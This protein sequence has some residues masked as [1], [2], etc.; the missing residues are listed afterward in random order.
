MLI[1]DFFSRVKQ[2]QYQVDQ[3]H[4]FIS[5]E[6]VF[7]ELIKK[8]LRKNGNYRTVFGQDVSLEWLENNILGLSLFGNEDYIIVEAH[9]IAKNVLERLNESLANIDTRLILISDKKIEQLEKFNTIEI[10]APNFWQMDKLLDFFFKVCRVKLSPNAM[11]F[12]LETQEAT[13]HNYYQIAMILQSNFPGKVVDQSDVE[14]V[15]EK[16]K[17]DKFEYASLLSRKDTQ[18]FF[19]KLIEIKSDTKTLRNFFLF[20]QTHMLKI[21]DPSYTNKKN[22]LS[23]YDNEIL[24]ANKTWTAEEIDN[25]LDVFR[26][27]EQVSK[28]TP[29]RFKNNLESLGLSYL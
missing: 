5:N 8:Y 15:I 3:H 6:L 25:I 7:C 21:F 12:V 29:D 14:A 28:L 27:L 11:Q 16:N 23:K 17:L 4:L 2:G 13:I 9:K 18:Q 20:M 22:K 26:K 10:T 1:W 24:N 19:R